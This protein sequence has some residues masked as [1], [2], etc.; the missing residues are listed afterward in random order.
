MIHFMLVLDSGTHLDGSGVKFCS[1]MV[2]SDSKLVVLDPCWVH[3][4]PVGPL[5]LQRVVVLNWDPRA[6]TR[7]L[8]LG[9]L[10]GQR[11]S[12]P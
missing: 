11:G 7:A 2:V 9:P 1:G 10:V 5:G 3:M 8:P 12:R 6:F 4:G